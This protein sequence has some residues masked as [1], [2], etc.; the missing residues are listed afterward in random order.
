MQDD[1][2]KTLPTELQKKTKA[3]T[4]SIGSNWKVDFRFDTPG[5]ARRAVDFWKQ[6][7][8]TLNGRDLWASLE[9]SPDAKARIAKL[10]RAA[11][12]LRDEQWKEVNT[13]GCTSKPTNMVR[14]TFAVDWSR[15]SLVRT[16]TWMEIG[17]FN[18][19]GDF[20]WDEE[21]KQGWAPDTGATPIAV[22]NS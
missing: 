2:I 10:M 4:P 15:Q 14:G 11:N 13:R 19:S 3:L 6:K 5:D 18:R 20:V 12:D 7:N 8:I 22:D 9:K 21:A 16:D 17:A 1:A